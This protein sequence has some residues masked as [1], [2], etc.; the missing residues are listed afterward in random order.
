MGVESISGT[1]FAVVAG[2]ASGGFLLVGL[3][4]SIVAAKYRFWP[5]GD[6]DWTFYVGWLNW[7]IYSGSFLFLAYHDSGSLFVSTPAMSGS[8]VLLILFG[9]ALSSIAIVQVGLTTS[10]GVRTDLHTQGVYR[11]SRNPQY[12]GFIAGIVGV[13]VMSGSGSASLVGV[14]GILWFIIAPLAEEPWLREQYGEAYDSYRERTPRF[15][16][17]L[18]NDNSEE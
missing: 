2:V 1:G 4:I 12:V 6:R 15:V 5:H 17:L 7:S 16:G 8:G 9:M 14:F 3:G 18:R 10:T 13:L 11:Y